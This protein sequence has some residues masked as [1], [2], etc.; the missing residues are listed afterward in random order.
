MYYLKGPSCEQLK[1]DMY[2]MEEPY[3]ARRHACD[4]CRGQLQTHVWSVSLA[5]AHTGDRKHI[6]GVCAEMMILGGNELLYT[7]LISQFEPI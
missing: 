2:L 6:S 1:R 7:S 3:A 4:A 5:V